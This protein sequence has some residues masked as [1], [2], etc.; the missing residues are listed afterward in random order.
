[1]DPTVTVGPLISARQRDNVEHLIQTGL[2]EG[3]QIA[4]GG[5]RP[6]HLDRGFFVEPTVFIG[7]DNSMAIAQREFFGPVTV[8]IPFDTDEQAIRLANQS[9]YGLAGG[10]WSASPTRAFRIG[11]QIRTGTVALNGGSTSL[12][13]F[14]AF[15]GYKASG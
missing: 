10:V 14:G 1:I 5:G 13:P 6:R 11:E 7:V 3:A 4:A 15:G 9:D 12:S 2:D 8:L